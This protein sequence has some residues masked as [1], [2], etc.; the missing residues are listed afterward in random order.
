MVVYGRP[1]ERT[2]VTRIPGKINE[3]PLLHPVYFIGYLRGKPGRKTVFFHG[4][5]C[6]GPEIDIMEMRPVFFHAMG[7]C[8]R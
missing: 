5:Q 3:S 2:Q 7:C 6:N 4:M 1:Q 8:F